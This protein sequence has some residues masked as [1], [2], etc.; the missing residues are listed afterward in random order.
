[1]RLLLSEDNNGHNQALITD[2]VKSIVDKTRTIKEAVIIDEDSI[3]ESTV[4][5]NML[6]R[7][8]NNWTGYEVS[9]NEFQIENELSSCRDV[10]AFVELLKKA[11]EKKYTDRRFKVFAFF[12]GGTTTVHFHVIREDEGAWLDANL[13][14]YKNPIVST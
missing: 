6:F 8:V 14:K 2:L 3:D 5:F 12:D 11:L 4:N 13:E 7:F 10:I 9:C 1:M